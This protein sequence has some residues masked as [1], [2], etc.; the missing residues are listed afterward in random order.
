MKIGE[1][2][3]NDPQA[4]DEYV[5]TKLW[6]QEIFREKFYH[7]EYEELP[8]WIKLGMEM[9][10]KKGVKI[11]E[12]TVAERVWAPGDT[13]LVVSEIQVMEGNGFKKGDKVKVTIENLRPL[14]STVRDKS[15][16]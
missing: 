6:S 16:S 2:L 10:P 5:D 1:E 14:E 8:A 13:Y 11:A 4:R 12:T 7:L 9:N 15:G 3:W